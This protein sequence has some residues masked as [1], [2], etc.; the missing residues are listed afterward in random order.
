MSIQP[1]TF[2]KAV[3]EHGGWYVV[4]VGFPTLVAAIVAQFFLSK[5][6]REKE[7]DTTRAKWDKR[8]AEFAEE[9]KQW[10][11][12]E[13]HLMKEIQKANDAHLE[14]LKAGP[15]IEHLTQLANLLLGTRSRRGDKNDR[16]DESGG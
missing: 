10:A 3:A 12:T 11:L 5:Y 8:E 1:E 9:R 13:L 15:Q 2:S 14:T 6:E 4:A 16:S 7:R